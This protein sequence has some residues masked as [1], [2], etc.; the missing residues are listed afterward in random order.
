VA[1]RHFLF[2]ASDELNRFTLLRRY[3]AN[4][5]MGERQGNLA[6]LPFELSR[7][8]GQSLSS[9]PEFR[10]FT[11]LPFR[12]ISMSAFTSAI[13][14]ISDYAFAGITSAMGRPEPDSRTATKSITRKSRQHGQTVATEL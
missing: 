11:L 10:G 5:R 3:L 2:A 13:S 6:T 9:A 12:G 8:Q 14:R 7:W 4:G 1:S